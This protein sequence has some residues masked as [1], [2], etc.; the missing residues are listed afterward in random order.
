MEIFKECHCLYQCYYE[1]WDSYLNIYPLKI[2]VLL[3]NH[4]NHLQTIFFTQEDWILVILFVK[5]TFFIPPF[6]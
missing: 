3:S 2:V 6:S 4:E 1:N 5:T